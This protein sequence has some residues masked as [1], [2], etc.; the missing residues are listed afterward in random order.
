MSLEETKQSEKNNPCKSC[1]AELNYQP[2]SEFLK[3]DYC[4]YREE[5]V[6]DE[7]KSV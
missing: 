1:G 6:L 5:I 7:K 2:G 3:C 4:G